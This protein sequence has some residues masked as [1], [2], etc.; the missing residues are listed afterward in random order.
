MEVAISIQ[1]VSKSI[2][3]RIQNS[4]GPYPKVSK[5][6]MSDSMRNEMF[7]PPHA[8]ILHRSITTITSSSEQWNKTDAFSKKNFNTHETKN[9]TF[10]GGNMKDDT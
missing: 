6:P 10:H 7:A 4:S 2:Q 1:K 5:I 9:G 3:N 8:L